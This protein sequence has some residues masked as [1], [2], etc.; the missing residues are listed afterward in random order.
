MLVKDISLKRS[1]FASGALNSKDAHYNNNKA[2]YFQ[3]IGQIWHGK[4][5]AILPDN[6]TTD[7]NNNTIKILKK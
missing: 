3:Q 2:H 4:T 7:F 5:V 1:D 6:E